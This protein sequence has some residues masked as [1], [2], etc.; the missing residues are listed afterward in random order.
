M[1]RCLARVYYTIGFDA[2]NQARHSPLLIEQI[3]DDNGSTYIDAPVTIIAYCLLQKQV[4]RHQLAG[5][6]LSLVSHDYCGTEIC[7]LETSSSILP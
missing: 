3:L 2:N 6:L 4:Q 5:R 1:V 7:S